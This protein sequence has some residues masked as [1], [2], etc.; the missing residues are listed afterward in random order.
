LLQRQQPDD[1]V[2]ALL[3]TRDPSGDP[4]VNAVRQL[5]TGFGYNFYD[6]KNVAR[7][8]D[9]LVRAKAA[10]ILGDAGRALARLEYAYRAEYCPPPSREQPFL[11]DAV[12][13]PLKKLERVIRRLADVETR[14]RSAETPA[15]DMIWF[16]VRNEQ[17]VLEKLLAFDV[18]LA[19]TA[20]DLAQRVAKLDAGALSGTALD[21]L[22][23]EIDELD[24]AFDTRAQ[25]M[26]VP[27]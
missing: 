27:T 25:L 1:V 26:A 8:N 24:R 17:R 21:E 12:T 14:I 7:A 11:P 2:R 18:G 22:R 19:V 10:G 6:A 23:A 15:T 3:D 4:I 5:M 13:Q 20:T 9:Q 16:R